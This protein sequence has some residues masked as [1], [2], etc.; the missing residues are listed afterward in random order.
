MH[1]RD[2][3]S[4]YYAKKVFHLISCIDHSLKNEFALSFIETD[5]TSHSPSHFGSLISNIITSEICNSPKP[6]SS[7]C[8]HEH[9]AELRSAGNGSA[10]PQ[11]ELQGIG[12]LQISEMTTF[13]MNDQKC[14][15][16]CDVSSVSMNEGVNS[17][18]S[19]WHARAS[20]NRQTAF[21]FQFDM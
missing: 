3:A 19:E 9:S 4:S 6:W 1:G 21:R 10:E 15:A 11:R 2:L 16:L 8:D 18:L 17:F 5:E 14:D 13:E 12:E 20:L 7:L